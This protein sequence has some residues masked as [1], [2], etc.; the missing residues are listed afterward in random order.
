MIHRRKYNDFNKNLQFILSLNVGDILRTGQFANRA[1]TNG[2][3]YEQ[4]NPRTGH[5]TNGLIRERGL[6]FYEMLTVLE[7]GHFAKGHYPSI[8]V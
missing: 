2:T 7:A 1:F 3:F 5:F 8:W 6:S 4:A